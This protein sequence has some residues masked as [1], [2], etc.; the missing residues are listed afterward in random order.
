[1]KRILAFVVCLM[2]LLAAGCKSDAPAQTAAPTA[3]PTVAPTTQPTVP[4]TTEPVV[5]EPPVTEP[6]APS[7]VPG[8]A[9]TNHVVVIRSFLER[10]SVIDI[11]GEFDENYYVAKTEDGYGLIEKLIVRL[12]G[13]QPYEAWTGYAQGGA[14]LFAGYHLPKANVRNLDMNTP[15][16]ILELFEDICLVQVGEELGYMLRSQISAAPIVYIPSEDGGDISLRVQGG[17]NLLSNFVPNEGE[18]TG[19]ATVL[20]DDAELLVGW[21]DLGESI[22]L[23]TDTGFAEAREGYLVAYRDGLWGY[24]S[25]NLVAYETD[26]PF[27]QWSGFAKGSVPFYDNYHL[28]GEPVRKL[29]INTEVIVLADLDNCFLVSVGGELGYMAQDSIS[30]TRIIVSGGGDEYTPPAL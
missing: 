18:V 13:Q 8:L 6:P 20:V 29:N 7:S 10:G 14:S 1:M 17:L 23:V 3:A 21:Y 28:A 16:Q 11:V 24:V 27:A 9:L 12:D 19:T 15:V 30:T 5:T 25:E 2:M 4:P 26:E 22:D